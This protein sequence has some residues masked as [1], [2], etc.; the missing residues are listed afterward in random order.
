MS[1]KD[2]WGKTP[3]DEAV[4][5]DNGKVVQE[6]L[7]EAGCKVGSSKMAEQNFFRAISEGSIDR[8][9]SIVSA[10]TPVTVVDSENRSAMHHAAASGQLK[11]IEY[12]IGAGAKLNVIDNFGLTPL[13]EA[14][15]H[16]SRTGENRVRDV[17]IAAG[18]DS[19]LS[20][21]SRFQ[22]MV[23]AALLGSTQLLFFGLFSGVV[24]FDPTLTT[25][26]SAE[27]LKTTYSM[28]MDVHVMI[29]I[30]FGFLMTFLRKYGHSSVG[31]NFLLAAFS[32][33]WYVLCGGFFEQA[34]GDAP[35]HFI[36]V[37]LHSL[38]L[39][40]FAA[41][42]ILI[43]FG[44]LLG[45]VSPL[46]MTALA[47]LEIICFSVSEQVLYKIGILD[48][49]GSIVV[50]LFGAYFGL[51]ASWVLSPKSASSNN[52]NASVYHSDLFAMIGTVFLW[53][54][55]PSFVASPAGP[56]DQERAMIAT[57]LSLTGSCVAAFFTSLVLRRGKFSMVDVQNATLAG[58][59][60]IGSSANLAVLSPSESILIGVLGGGLSVCGYVKIQ[61]ML[62][63]WVGV[64]DTCGVNNLHGM[65]ALLAAIASAI[66]MAYS[67]DSSTFSAATS[68]ATHSAVYAILHDRGRSAEEQAGY[69]IVCALV[70][71]AI[72]IGSGLVC[73][74]LTKLLGSLPDDALFLDRN[75]WEVP[76]LELPFYFDQRGEINRETIAP[77]VTL[78]LS[79]HGGSQFVDL[80][81]K[82]RS[83]STCALNCAG[84]GA[85]SAY[86][87][88]M[89]TP[90][91][92][93]NE[94]INMK[95]DLLLQHQ[96]AMPPTP[97]SQS[98][99]PTL[100]SPALPSVTQMSVSPATT[101]QHDPPTTESGS[102]P[103]P[104]NVSTSPVLRP[105]GA[106]VSAG[107]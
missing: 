3:L 54:Y 23:F 32:I 35:W 57:T 75:Y 12:L 34:F 95:L 82:Q 69:Q 58:G 8:V 29:F 19:E 90:S 50:H 100:P 48:V 96:M 63:R 5:A 64:H 49:G 28:F 36:H 9:E 83:S 22:T 81:G 42:V 85:S 67:G 72:A 33:Q 44:A 41:A 98:R 93:S 31:L 65:P 2:T 43:T 40:D 17:L 70:S 1:P 26:Q 47:F 15:R 14:D 60:A 13:G 7:V 71:L 18:A 39:A 101:S 21:E 106:G 51:A 59:V 88:P 92:I 56:L 30:G 79:K 105:A 97:P 89:N 10:G 104:L 76:N 80:E 73:G 52:D 20:G 107:G 94:L 78:E 16:R 24:R 53:I 91:L 84:N 77:A 103:Y 74:K 66:V 38:L 99:A 37:N 62:E 55:W 61:P 68:N 45:K 86:S 46:Q 6:M 11:M 102:V 4:E 87:A 25:D 27:R